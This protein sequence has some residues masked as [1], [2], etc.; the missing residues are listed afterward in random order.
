MRLEIFI[1]RPTWT[2]I[3]IF[4]C[5]NKNKS[6]ADLPCIKIT[7]SCNS[8]NVC[9][10]YVPFGT[11]ATN[12]AEFRDCCVHKFI[13]PILSKGGYCH[14]PNTM[15]AAR[16][17][18]P[19]LLAFKRKISRTKQ[20]K[21]SV[22]LHGTNCW[23][24]SRALFGA[25]SSPRRG[26][27]NSQA[28]PLPAAQPLTK[29][30][31]CRAGYDLLFDRR[32]SIFINQKSPHFVLLPAVQIICPR[33]LS[34]P[35]PAGSWMLYLETPRNAPTVPALSRGASIARVQSW[36]T[37]T[38]FWAMQIDNVGKTKGFI[39]NLHTATSPCNSSLFKKRAMWK[40]RTEAGSCTLGEWSQILPGSLRQACK[41]T[42]FFSNPGQLYCNSVTQ[43][44]NTL[45]Q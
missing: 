15:W 32:S 28:V 16:E 45:A 26:L 2:I 44:S 41:R 6:E 22:I 25:R 5:T 20:P 27:M 13:T 29:M 21:K 1:L 9:E 24:T 36:E 19:A 42:L 34:I 11:P 4:I 40:G 17:K 23:V 39:S 18:H 43:D 8:H 7:I 33:V 37:A 12:R 3:V 38:V 31:I 10:T 35:S 30:L 14:V